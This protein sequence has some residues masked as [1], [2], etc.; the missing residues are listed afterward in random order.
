MKFSAV[1]FKK[2]DVLRL[3][4]YHKIIQDFY[5]AGNIIFAVDSERPENYEGLVWVKNSGSLSDFLFEE[6][7]DLSKELIIVEKAHSEFVRIIDLT[8]DSFYLILIRS[9][10]LLIATHWISWKV[11]FLYL[12]LSIASG[13]Y[14]EL[15]IK[16]RFVV[17][18]NREINEL[19]N[20][21]YSQYQKDC[22][23]AELE[24]IKTLISNISSAMRRNMTCIVVT[25]MV[26]TA[27]AA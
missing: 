7:V 5:C 19:E 21:I 9:I 10:L 3:N 2:F 13:L 24:W 1:W 8:E 16:S 27:P 11:A 12:T 25:E 18:S 17:C 23:T 20:M 15:P 26:E 22:A 14:R 4:D 6:N